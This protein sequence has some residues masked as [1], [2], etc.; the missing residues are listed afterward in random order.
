MVEQSTA[1]T[2]QLRQQAR[3]LTE[4]VQVFKVRHG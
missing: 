3:A 2:H 1:T 4:A